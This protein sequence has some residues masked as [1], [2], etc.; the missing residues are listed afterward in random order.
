M[1]DDKSNLNTTFL[2][3]FNTTFLKDVSHVVNVKQGKIYSLG[4]LE[5]VL[6]EIDNAID[7]AIDDALCKGNERHDEQQSTR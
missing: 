4:E 1:F 5:D 7:N 6:R 3:N 2:K